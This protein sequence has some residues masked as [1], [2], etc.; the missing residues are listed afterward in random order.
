MNQFHGTLDNGD[1]E[2]RQ[3]TTLKEA[4]APKRMYL[5]E[6]SEGVMH[7][8]G[9]YHGNGDLKAR[10]E[11]DLRDGDNFGDLMCPCKTRCPWKRER[12]EWESIIGTLASRLLK[13]NTR[14]NGQHRI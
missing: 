11:A 1:E 8:V 5:C 7:G 6:L 9:D 2:I 4:S 13:K 12:F 14:T 3:W 10:R